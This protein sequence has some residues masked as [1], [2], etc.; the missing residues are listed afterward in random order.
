MDKDCVGLIMD[1]ELCWAQL[2]KEMCWA[3]Y[4]LKKQILSILGKWLPEYQTNK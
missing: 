4:L 3:K 2:A 1:K